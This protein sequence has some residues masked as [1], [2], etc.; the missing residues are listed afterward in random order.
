MLVFFSDGVSEAPDREGEPFGDERIIT[1][2][3]SS[4]DADVNT[5]LS[6]LIEDVRRYSGHDV[7]DDDVSAL[8][9]R[10]LGGEAPQ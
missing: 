1:S 4:L 10:F 2:V 7:P 3:H 8:V 6:R 5:L 9:L